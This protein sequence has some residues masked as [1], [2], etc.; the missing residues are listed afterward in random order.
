MS[1]Y[2]KILREK[3]EG[4]K[5]ENSFMEKHWD[6]MEMKMDTPSIEKPTIKK[7]KLRN[8]W[9][10]LLGIAVLAIIGFF[11][12]K[13]IKTTIHNSKNENN[14]IATSTIKPPKPSV[15]VPFETFSYD[16]ENGD[17]LFTQNGSILIFPKNAV[18][19]KNGDIVTG[20][21]EV[22]TREF[23]DPIDYYMAGIPMQ[24]DSAGVQYTFVSSAMIDIKAYQNKELLYVN[25][26]AKPQLNLVSTNNETKANLYTLDTT[27]GQWINKGKEEVFDLA[28][29]K[30]TKPINVNTIDTLKVISTTK[31]RFSKPLLVSEYDSP[32]QML[33]SKPIAPQKAS[34]KNP[35][36]QIEID[37]ASFKELLIYNNLKFEVIGGDT[38]NEADSKIEWQDIQLERHL[39]DDNYSVQF[40]STQRKVTYEVKPVL[41]NSDY[42]AAVKIYDEKIKEYT[43]QM[44]N[45]I[46]EQQEIVDDNKE[47]INE[48][49]VQKPSTEKKQQI[50]NEYQ[51]VEN[52][53]IEALNKL[54]IARNKQIEIENVA[55]AMENK[56]ILNEI[57][58]N[59][60]FQDSLKMV[61]EKQYRASVLNQNLLRTFE[62]DGFGYW[63]CDQPILADAFYVKATFVDRENKIIDMNE[64]TAIVKNVNRI[65][66]INDELPI[67]K[68]QSHSIFGFANDH[69]YYVTFNEFDALPITNQTKVYTFK[70][71]KYEGKTNTLSD[72]KR[73][74]FDKPTIKSLP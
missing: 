33:I 39:I 61:W 25:P 14:S 66:R 59:K 30:V 56:R 40:S 63:N 19:H 18:L 57:E 6:A 58:K 31:L 24:Y 65:T 55:T 44:N 49:I 37:P 1:N 20:R 51:L 70:L 42:N 45:R 74:I 62:I 16:A 43:T 23:N 47:I 36:I 52:S 12:F 50:K 53:K 60:K 67:V 26:K 54:I 34:G 41:E 29:I 11:T 64:A 13:K 7:G 35:I 15:N 27:N 3:E 73:I 10:G 38:W 68:K 5:L 21:V 22:Q 48:N 69:F 4:S 17:T 2:D 71:N 8:L 46:K 9:K 28:K 72:L 32:N